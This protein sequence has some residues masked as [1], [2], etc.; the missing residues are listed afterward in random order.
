MKMCSHPPLVSCV[1]EKMHK[2]LE[3]YERLGGE[4]DIVNPANEL[5]KEGHIK[6]MSAKNGTAQDRYLYLVR[7]RDVTAENESM[8]RGRTC[9]LT[10]TNQL[11]L[12]QFNNMVLYCVPKLRLMGQKFSVR[13]R[14]DIAGMEVRWRVSSCS[15]SF[16]VPRVINPS[17]SHFW[18]AG[19][20]EREA[21]PSSHVR[22]HRQAA[23][24]GA[25]SQVE[26]LLYVMS[27]ICEIYIH[28]KCHIFYC[29]IIIIIIIIIFTS[30]YV[31]YCDGSYELASSD[32][33]QCVFAE[34]F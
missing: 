26:I 31:S 34:S 15:V 30:C 20:G 16:S 28:Y 32:L 11:C 29:N 8:Q 19:A 6:K 24:T 25:S 33:L 12:I 22:H 27:N 17:S 3:V 13:E 4:E 18:T 1:Q 23:F 2:L 21:E 7:G 14:I 5:I 10:R 9:L